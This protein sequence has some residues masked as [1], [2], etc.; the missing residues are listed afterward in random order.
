MIATGRFWA[1]IATGLAFTTIARAD[2]SVPQVPTGAL[3]GRTQVFERGTGVTLGPF[4]STRDPSAVAVAVRPI[5]ARE[6]FTAIHRIRFDS[7]GKAEWTLRLVHGA[8]TLES[9]S[10]ADL[11]RENREVFYWTHEVPPAGVSL[12]V[13]GNPLNL[14][15]ELDRTQLFENRFI[16]RVIVCLP[17]DIVRFNTCDTR[18]DIRSQAGSL[19]YK[20]GRA[21]VALRISRESPRHSN[22]DGLF[23]CTGFRVAEDLIATAAHCWDYY[24]DYGE[25]VR[26]AT[27]EF[28]S[29]L[30]PVQGTDPGG[31]RRVRLA[32]EPAYLSQARDFAL[33]RFTDSPPATLTLRL[34]A[35]D[36]PADSIPLRLIEN[37]VIPESSIPNKR[38]TDRGCQRMADP[39]AFYEPHPA[40]YPHTCDIEV[41]ASGAPLF[42]ADG[43]VVGI[44]VGGL[45]SNEKAVNSASKIDR[46]YKTMLKASTRSDLSESERSQIRGILKNLTFV[47]GGGR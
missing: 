7:I 42:D 19:I 3:F 21:V 28:F 45:R 41:T 5:P 39:P 1:L 30:R 4:L 32:L 35:S 8:D 2:P 27:A 26:E 11:T 36:A 12:V 10:V 15:A 31:S 17:D 14:K 40:S 33:L 43:L 23:G 29:E 34:N 9:L 22:R 25:R 16:P 47:T 20:L 24:H 37:G 13:D 46:I 18:V 38:V 44:H 6:G